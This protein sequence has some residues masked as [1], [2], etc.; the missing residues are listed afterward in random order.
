MWNQV[1]GL[2][3]RFVHAYTHTHT[4][5]HTFPHT[6]FI[7]SLGEICNSLLKD[8]ETNREDEGMFIQF[9]R[10][11]KATSASCVIYTKEGQREIK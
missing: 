7:L 8:T 6:P 3:A 2:K 4:Q 10:T 11:S 5:A 9:Y 1:G